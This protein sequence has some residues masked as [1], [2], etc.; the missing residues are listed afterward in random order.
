MITTQIIYNK[1][2]Q[3][4]ARFP[5]EVSEIVREQ[6]KVTEDDIKTN[7]QK[8]D[9]IDTGATLNSVQSAMTGQFSGEVTVGTEYAVYGNYGTRYQTARPFAS[10]AAV[11]GETEFPERFRELEGR[12]G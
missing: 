10:D 7:I 4:R 12:L 3:V 2:P 1:L 9:Y 11:T 6:I 5:R 8:Y